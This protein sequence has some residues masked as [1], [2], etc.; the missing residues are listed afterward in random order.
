MEREIILKKILASKSESDIILQDALQL[1]RMSREDLSLMIRTFLAKKFPLE[2]I[3][4]ETE[5]IYDLAEESL[6]LILKKDASEINELQ[7]GCSGATSAM[8][9]KV[10]FFIALQRALNIKFA[11]EA[12]V[13]IRTVGSM[14]EFCYQA[15]LQ[16]SD[17]EGDA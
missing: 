6:S 17:E 10:L 7:S 3:P 14:T 16:K 9:K 11:E 15:L 5:R 4:D 12:A 1:K 8:A 13:D 2:R